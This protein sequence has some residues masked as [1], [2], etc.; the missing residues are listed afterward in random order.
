MGTEGTPVY[1]GEMP[2]PA[3]TPSPL[4]DHEP[5]EVIDMPHGRLERRGNAIDWRDAEGKLWILG[6]T[7][8]PDRMLPLLDGLGIKP[9]PAEFLEWVW[10][11]G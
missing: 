11:R 7:E 9:V 1:S 6:M 2:A 8:D 10:S 4:D 3:L 5:D